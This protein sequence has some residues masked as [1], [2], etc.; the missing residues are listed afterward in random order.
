MH[1][2]LMRKITIQLNDQSLTAGNVVDGHILVTCDDDFQCERLFVSLQGKEQARVVIHAGKV[3]IIHQEERDHIDH[4]ID[5][6]ENLTIPMGESRYDFSFT[7]P[8]NIPGSY[9]GP[10]GSIKYTIEAKAEI[11]WARDLK[12]KQDLTLAFKSGLDAEFVPE[13]KSDF[14]END[15]IVLVKAETTQNRFTLGNDVNLRFYVDRE[16]KMRGIRAE[17]IRVEHVEPKGHNMD[18]KE[19][20]AENYYPDDEIR[21][22]S[23]TEVTLPTDIS[24]V[25]SFTTDLIQYT[26]IL[27]ITQDIA[28]R[29]D[30]DIEIPIVLT[31][32]K[33]DSEFDF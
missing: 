9:K 12:S 1:E 7:L 4:Y 30:K 29:R 15:G 31:R 27:K 5:L 28:R 17:I 22:D 8:P 10:Y 16:A 24:W 20:L 6:D 13:S 21:R 19:S 25:E 33:I 23:W 3:T 2:I 14:I 32:E 26:H 18:S 11:S